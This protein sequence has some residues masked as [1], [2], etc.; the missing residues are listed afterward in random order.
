MKKD[1]CVIIIND[2]GNKEKVMSVDFLEIDNILFTYPTKEN[3]ISMPINR[4]IK[5]KE[6]RKKE[7][8]DNGTNYRN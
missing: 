8:G 1:K 7:N 3:L 6:E 2:E 4:L 5:I